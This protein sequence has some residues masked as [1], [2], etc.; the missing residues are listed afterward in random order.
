MINI[1]TALQHAIN[2]LSKDNPS[3]RLE[4]EILLS[5][6]LT[7]PRTFIYAYPEVLLSASQWQTYQQLIS[8]R[9]MGTPVAY[10]TG[11]REFWSLPIQV[12][13]DTLIPR[14]ETELLVELTLTLLANKTQAL[15][16]DLGTGSGAIALALASERPN[17]QIIAADISSSAIHIAHTNASMFDLTNIRFFCSDWFATIPPYLFDAIVSNPPYIA[18]QDPHLTQGDVRFEPH[19]ALVSGIKGLDALNHLIQKSIS[20]LQPNGLLLLEHGYDQ[21]LEVTTKLTQLG[22]DKVQ[23]WQDMQGNDR[24]SGG[25]FKK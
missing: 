17:W 6:T 18:E 12:N 20:H 3:A 2:C 16:L 23:C 14:P 10:L 8:Q 15:I 25:W 24:V 19:Q 1:Q 4:A 13:K 22:Y 7:K 5:H 21:K 11:I 9:K